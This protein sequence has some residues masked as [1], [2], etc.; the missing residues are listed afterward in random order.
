MVFLHSNYRVLCNYPNL[1]VHFFSKK[2]VL[3]S[4]S[5]YARSKRLFA[6][7]FVS[8]ASLGG[9]SSGVAAVVIYYASILKRALDRKPASSCMKNGKVV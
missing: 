9:D 7:Y 1:T 5:I 6:L 4:L 3:D 2:A 8:L